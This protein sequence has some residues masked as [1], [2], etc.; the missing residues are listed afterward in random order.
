MRCRCVSDYNTY[1]EADAVVEDDLADG[2]LANKHIQLA[3]IILYST[4]YSI[5]VFYN[6]RTVL[7]SLNLRLLQQLVRPIGYLTSVV[8]ENE[9][10]CGSHLR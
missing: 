6:D 3:I 7:P 2:E 1:V 9:E 10:E 8:R 4:I 5:L